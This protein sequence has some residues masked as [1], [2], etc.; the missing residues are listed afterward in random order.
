MTKRQEANV[1][2]PQ[3]L[4]AGAVCQLGTMVLTAQMYNTA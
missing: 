2:K 4:L 1:V 3:N